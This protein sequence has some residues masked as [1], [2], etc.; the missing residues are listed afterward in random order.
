LKLDYIVLQEAVYLKN[1]ELIAG[2]KK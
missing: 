2:E 1:Y